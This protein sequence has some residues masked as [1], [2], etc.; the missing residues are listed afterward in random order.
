MSVFKLYKGHLNP[1]DIYGCPPDRDPD[2]VQPENPVGYM[3]MHRN[4]ED[5]SW[6]ELCKRLKQIYGC[7]C[8]NLKVGDEIEWAL[9]P[10]FSEVESIAYRS[11]AYQAGFMF[12]VHFDDRINSPAPWVG[13]TTIKTLFPDDS[14]STTEIVGTA[15]MVG[16]HQGPDQTVEVFRKDPSMPVMVGGRAGVAKIVITGV[17]G[18]PPGPTCGPKGP[19]FHL[20]INYRNHASCCHSAS[21]P[22][23]SVCG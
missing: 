6:C 4:Y 3:G 23:E 20:R 9:V 11:G 8:A 10:S 21:C 13:D 12:D 22:C 7:D 15:E 5:A 17:P 19:N 1:I 16:M 2:C 14:C 18:E